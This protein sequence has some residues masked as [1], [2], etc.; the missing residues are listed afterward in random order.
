MAPRKKL[1]YFQWL[2]KLP[3]CRVTLGWKVAKYV[4]GQKQ[5]LSELGYPDL[6]YLGKSD[7]GYPDLPYLGKSDLGYPDLPYLGKS[8]LGY[9]DLP[10]LGKSDLGYP[11][12]PYLGKSSTSEGTSST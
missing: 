3:Y 9:P 12:L 5:K 8:D 4:V 11:D 2:P 7:L 1:P 10:Y 6:P